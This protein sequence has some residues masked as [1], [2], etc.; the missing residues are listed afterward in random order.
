M[1]E[2]YGHILDVETLARF[3][4][5]AK[6]TVYRLAEKRDLPGHKVGGQWRF[7]RDEVEE[8]IRERR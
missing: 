4:G 3:L 8:W 7:M 2:F 5:V 1:K 6:I